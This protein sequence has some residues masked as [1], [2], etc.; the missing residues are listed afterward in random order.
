MS[1][2]NT[3]TLCGEHTPKPGRYAAMSI[4]DLIGRFVKL[5]FVDPPKHGNKGELLWVLV[6]GRGSAGFD[7]QGTV[8]NKP[9]F[10]EN[11]SYGSAVVF[12]RDEIVELKPTEP[13]PGSRGWV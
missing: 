5:R 4:D 8:R 3:R 9:T 11:V 6:T 7:L 2:S 10:L 1:K 13:A 12:D